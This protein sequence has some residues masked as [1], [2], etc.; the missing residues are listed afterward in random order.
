MATVD[1]PRVGRP[2]EKPD[3]PLGLRIRSLMERKRM[4]KEELASAT[5]IHVRAVYKILTGDTEEPKG[6]NLA[7]IAAVLGTTYAKLTEGLF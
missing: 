5:G 1:T 2:K 7:K 4:T 3:C 6:S